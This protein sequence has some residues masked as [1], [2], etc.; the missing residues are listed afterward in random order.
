MLPVL[1]PVSRL[2]SVVCVTVS[3]VRPVPL[4]VCAV[5]RLVRGLCLAL[6]CVPLPLRPLVYGVLIAPP[7][8]PC[9]C[10]VFWGFIFL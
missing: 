4:S 3:S 2:V 8:A 9:M 5:A 1:C 7:Y 6:P 10:P